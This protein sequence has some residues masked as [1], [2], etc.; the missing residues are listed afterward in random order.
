MGIDLGIPAYGGHG[1]YASWPKCDRCSRRLGR[2]YP[3]EKIELEG[4]GEKPKVVGS[5]ARQVVVCSCHGHVHRFT[6]EVPIW[7]GDSMRMQA[8]GHVLCFIASPTGYQVASTAGKA[9]RRDGS[10]S[11]IVR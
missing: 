5:K 2:P 9:R 3:V 6:M 8:L 10:L 7:W 11:T 4:V 1:S